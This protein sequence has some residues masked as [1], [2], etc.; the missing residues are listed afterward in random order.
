LP[1]DQ[2]KSIH[3]IDQITRRKIKGRS[4]V[5]G[6]MQVL[7]GFKVP[8]IRRWLLAAG[9]AA[10]TPAG[11]LVSAALLWLVTAG[12]CIATLLVSRQDTYN[13]AV[14]DARNLTLV[15]ERDILRSVE[16]Y[17]LSLH[18]VAEG[19]ADARIMSLPKEL[20]DQ[21]LF[22]RAA[23]ARYLGPI[24]VFEP[25]GTAQVCSIENCPPR[26]HRQDVRWYVEQTEKTDTNLYISAPY[27]S[28]TAGGGMVLALSRQI[29]RPDGTFGGVVVGRLSIDYFRYLLDGL[30]MGN[31]SGVAVFET[32]G[33]LLARFPYERSAV[34][35][36]FRRS[37]VFARIMK[38]ETGAFVA[39]ATLDG[40]RRLY[41]YRRIRGLP[42]AVS[43]AP[44]LDE[45]YADWRWRAECVAVLMALFTAVM[46]VGTWALMSELRRRQLARAR[47]QRMA[48]RDA[49]TGLENRGTFDDV[50]ST[51]FLRSKRSGRPLSLLFIDIDNFKLY[52]DYYGHQAGDACLKSVAGCIAARARRPGDHVARYGGEEF[53]VVLPET[54]AGTAFSIAE[55]IRRAIY[56]LEIEHIES[57]FGTVT[58]SIGSASTEDADIAD[59]T[60]LIKAADMAT[61]DAKSLG[62]NRVCRHAAPA[63][64]TGDLPG[65]DPETPAGTNENRR[66][67]E[68]AAQ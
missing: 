50:W 44:A 9:A 58:V 52:N 8:A 23:T 10:Y 42:F 33:I 26:S 65:K 40:V 20:R 37:A 19:A 7:S 34:G 38:E 30:S 54:D 68:P 46:A 32:N 28:Q 27:V 25:D 3:E 61:Y 18:A 35:R 5:G 66:T 13:H 14:Q 31:H 2:K 62:R 4:G 24:T 64:F 16:F 1:S 45:V 57:R 21:V 59:A 11:L 29:T 6:S 22:D 17:D 48:H 36:D 56:E 15:L 39:A 55:E 51:E 49:L 63:G 60:A 12:L 47:L 53:V 67:E 41:V 43:V